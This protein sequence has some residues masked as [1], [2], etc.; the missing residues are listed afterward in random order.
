MT[1]KQ[2][3]HKK[4][5]EFFQSIWNVRPHYCVNCNK[6]LG[7]EPRSYHFDHLL[8]RKKYPEF[9]YE[10]KNIAL[11]CLDCHTNRHNGFPGSK[12]L[13]LIENARNLFIKPTIN[14]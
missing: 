10:R 11:V 3:E 9:E 12:H 7:H 13:K 4:R 8:E 2:Q 14:K 6:W 5:M 1:E